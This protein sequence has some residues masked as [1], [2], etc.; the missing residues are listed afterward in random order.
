VSHELEATARVAERVRIALEAPDLATFG[1]LLHPEV[2]WGAPGDPSPACQNR[3][4]VLAWYRRGH[5]AGVRAGVSEVAVLGRRTILVGLKVV[6]RPAASAGGSEVERWQ[7][8]TVDGDRVVEIVGFDERSDALAHARQVRALPDGGVEQFGLPRNLVDAVHGGDDER[9]RAWM[10]ALPGTVEQLEQDWSLRAGTPFQPGGQTAWVAPAHSEEHGDVVLKVAWRHK[11]AAHEAAGLR[12]WNGRGAVLVH[13]AQEFDD[14]VALL[15]ERCLP[16]DSLASRPEPE[17]DEVVASL[18]LRLW[19]APPPGHPF[20][21]LEQMC[22][23]WADTFERK[24]AARPA[25]LD[26]GLAREGIALFRTLPAEAERHVL[27]CTDLHAQNVLAAEREPWL[28]IDPKP[29]VGDPTYDVL[30]HLLNCEERLHADPDALAR[31]LADLLEL[32][33]ERLLLWLFARCVQESMDWPAL[34]DIARRIAP[35]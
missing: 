21:A 3:A 29:H 23:E 19:Q 25:S 32:D 5:E 1:E 10:A 20:R 4:Q 28:V 6:R 27:L 16:G 26:P 17:Q 15:L 8:L 11:E 9:R 31:R 2:R 18:L 7:V 12:A 35:G 34:A 13:A 33:A 30:Q 22:E 24:A 14:T